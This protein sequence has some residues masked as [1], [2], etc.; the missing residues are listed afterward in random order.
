MEDKF[1]ILDS[2]QGDV[3]IDFDGYILKAS[4]L[5]VSR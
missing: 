5:D 3:I 4:Q 2:E 1:Q